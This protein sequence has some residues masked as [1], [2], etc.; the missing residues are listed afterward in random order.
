MGK[1]QREPERTVSAS[2]AMQ[3]RA[4][5]CVFVNE[6]ASPGYIKLR[7]QRRNADPLRVFGL[8]SVIDDSFMVVGC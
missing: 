8:S 1:A 7:R 3:R 5:L 4:E 2:N 6:T